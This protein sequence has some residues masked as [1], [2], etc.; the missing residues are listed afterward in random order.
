MKKVS[1]LMLLLIATSSLL[2]SFKIAP[3]PAITSREIITNMLAKIAST[4][5]LSFKLKSW[6]RINGKDHFNDAD[7]K[8]NVNPIKLYI[9]SNADPNKN[10]EILYNE[11]AFGKK[12]KV[13]SPKLFFSLSMDPYGSTLRKDQHHP[14]LS[15]GFVYVGKVIS[16]A[17]KKADTEKKGEF[18]N[19]FKLDGEVKW[20]TIP[21][22]QITITDPTYKW[23]DYTV[24]KG[25]DLHSIEA[26]KYICGWLILEKNNLSDFTS[27]KAGQTIK[28]P[29]S[30]AKKTVLL[31]D[32]SN[33]LPIVQTMFDETGQFE[34]YEF[35]NLVVNPAFTEKDFSTD[36]PG[37]K[38]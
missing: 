9:H 33:M 14:F 17:V 12:A 38:F 30:Y 31:I 25:D 35:H 1:F 26:N 18:E 22:Y 4:K 11:A 36:G 15:S 5:T 16:E 3:T 32:K 13:S 6:E 37:Y 34:R 2:L 20:G 24:K 19:L 29:S 21:C 8:L 27:I 10:V 28:I 7:S 23:V